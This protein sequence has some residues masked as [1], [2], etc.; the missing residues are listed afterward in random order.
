MTA[1]EPK[2]DQLATFTQRLQAASKQLDDCPPSAIK[3]AVSDYL[4][5][6]QETFR[7]CRDNAQ[8]TFDLNTGS[9]WVVDND[10]QA[11]LAQAKRRCGIVLETMN[12]FAPKAAPKEHKETKPHAETKSH[13][14][15]GHHR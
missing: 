4:D 2:A 11:N 10:D 13:S 15:A 3:Q 6:E 14:H 7:Y 9:Q 1:T 8:V 12:Q 5:V